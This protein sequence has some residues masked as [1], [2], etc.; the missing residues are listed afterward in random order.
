MFTFH[1]PDTNLKGGS[2][3][4]LMHGSGG[5]SSDIIAKTNK[6]EGIAGKDKL[7]IIY[8]EGYLHFWNE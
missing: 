4:F 6:L 3:L 7:L 8:P 1:Q 2:L 5:N